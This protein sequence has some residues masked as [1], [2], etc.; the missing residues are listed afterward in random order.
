VGVEIHPVQQHPLLRN[1]RGSPRAV[2]NSWICCGGLPDRYHAALGAKLLWQETA[3]I[4]LADDK[5]IAVVQ[6]AFADLADA[7][8]II[9]AEKGQLLNANRSP[10]D[11]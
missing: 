6:Y 10:L 3:R 1:E 4:E 8:N 11:G 9:C 2:R 7:A 5:A